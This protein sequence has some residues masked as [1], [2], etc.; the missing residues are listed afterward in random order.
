MTKRIIKKMA[1]LITRHML[2]K[3]RAHDGPKISIH[4]EPTVYL[5]TSWNTRCGIAAYSA[6]LAAEL[7]KITKIRVV[8]ITNN[9]AFSPYYFV[10]G[11]TIGR[12]NSIVHVQFAYSM[13][14]GLKLWRR[15]GLSDFAALLFYFGL[16]FGRSLVVTTFHEV[17]KTKNVGGKVG[18]FY[19]KLLDKL[20]CTVSDLV[21]VLTSE[22]KERMVQNYGV[23]RSRLKVI[24]IGCVETPQFLNKD[25]CKEKLNLSKKT[26]LTIPGFV[27]KNHGHDVVISILPQLDKDV[28]LLIAGGART[29]ETAT[30]YEELKKMAQQYHCI[31]RITFIDDYPITA[32]ILSATD[33]AILPYRYST[34]SLTLRLLVAYKIPTITSDLSIFKKIKKEYDCI[35]LFRN[36][37]KDDLIAR[38]QSLL[39]NKR[40]QRLLQEQCQKIW[41]DNRWSIIAAKHAEAYLEVLSGHPDTIYDDKKQKERIDWLK[42]NVSGGALEIGCAGGFITSY[43]NA[44]VGL[45]INQWRI[46]FAKTKHPEKDFII[47]SAFS[48]PFKDKAFGTILIPEILEHVQLKQAEKIVS[49]SKCVAHKILITL[50]NAD[51]INYDKAIVENP[52]HLWFPTK[53]T[54]L[55]LIRDCKIQYTNENDFMLAHWP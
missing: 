41:K 50:P 33:I 14:S 3:L 24:P 49:E 17:P 47:A 48:L 45:D 20:V 38:I 12:S 4:S 31:E 18:L 10:R 30:Y 28:H 16:A 46:K 22:S 27:S 6:F 37:D 34:E 52:E 53:D 25:S 44:D 32:T 55:S 7:K 54:V 51:K 21:I 39:S 35:E 43:A 2:P 5:V 8:R 15:W 23:N 26:V 42:E 36:D 11:F 19:A 29:K 40:R 1:G 9:R 13:F